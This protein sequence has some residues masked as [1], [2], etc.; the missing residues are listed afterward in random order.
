MSESKTNLPEIPQAPKG[1]SLV[2]I[3]DAYSL[4]PVDVSKNL[5]VAIG[6][7]TGR[8]LADFERKY[9]CSID[10][11]FIRLNTVI[12]YHYMYQEILNAAMEEGEDHIELAKSATYAAIKCKYNEDENTYTTP[13]GKLTGSV[14]LNMYDV[15]AFVLSRKGRI[16]G[17]DEDT[18]E[19]DLEPV[20]F[21]SVYD[22]LNGSALAQSDGES[23]AF[24]EIM[25]FT[26]AHVQPEMPEQVEEE[27][28]GETPKDDEKG[29]S[30][31]SAK[32]K[33]PLKTVE[34]EDES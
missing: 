26:K 27:L 22:E 12:Y 4:R 17:Y 6:Q 7:L 9:K 15:L 25:S 30:Q 5:R 18:K 14:S 24:W 11:F 20:S 32:S 10:T 1:I 19:Y 31:K 34:K 2:N 29:K 23:N 13:A 21:E 28:V 8:D 33:T 16:T 3:D